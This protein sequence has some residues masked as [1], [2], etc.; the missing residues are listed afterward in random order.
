MA[1]SLRVNVKD[2]LIW[3]NTE[4][5]NNS[6]SKEVKKNF[7]L[8]SGQTDHSLLVKLVIDFTI[9]YLFFTAIFNSF[10]IF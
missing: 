9:I 8:K 6:T 1:F 4:D 2:A 3:E 7:H 10:H 5:V